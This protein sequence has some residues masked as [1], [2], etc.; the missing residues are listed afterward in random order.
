MCIRDRTEKDDELKA[1][2]LNNSFEKI[3]KEL[4]GN[5]PLKRI[6]EFAILKY[7]LNNKSISIEK[8]NSEILKYIEKIDED[9]VEHAFECLNHQYWD[10]SMIKQRIKMVEYKDGI[11]FRSN[12]FEE[13]INNKEYLKYIEDAMNYGILRYKNEFKDCLLYTS[14]F[15]C[16]LIYLIHK[17]IFILFMNYECFIFWMNYNISRIDFLYGGI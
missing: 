12:E 8:A 14:Q 5:L 3:L 4:N 6:N 9:S 7:L 16:I 17:F 11:L 10:S 13:V 2:L 15:K 1:L